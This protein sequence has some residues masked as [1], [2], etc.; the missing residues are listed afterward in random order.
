MNEKLPEIKS[1]KDITPEQ[2]A[3]YIRFVATMRH[4]QNRWFR[5]KKVDALEISRQMESQLDEL[6]G[7]LLNPQPTLF[8][9]V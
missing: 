5:F 8:D 3:Q 6:N 4:N 2:A 7:K 9:G 1:L